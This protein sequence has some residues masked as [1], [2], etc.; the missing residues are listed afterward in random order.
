MQLIKK[1]GLEKAEYWQKIEL[2]NFL[3]FYVYSCCTRRGNKRFENIQ[4]LHIELQNSV[5]RDLSTLMNTE[6]KDKEPVKFIINGDALGLYNFVE[7]SIKQFPFRKKYHYLYL[8]IY[9]VFII[10]LDFEN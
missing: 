1:I 3:K 4:L 5:Y 8:D 6:L 10:L 2:K 7:G 9:I